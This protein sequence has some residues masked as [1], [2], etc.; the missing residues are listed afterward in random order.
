MFPQ[1]A[2]VTGYGYHRRMMEKAI[3]K[4]RC[5]DR[6]AEHL[7][8][9][10][11][12]KAEVRGQDHASLPVAG[13]DQL[14]EQ[15]GTTLDNRKEADLVDN[16]ERGIDMGPHLGL[17]Q[18]DPFG[19]DQV[20]DQIRKG[21]PVDTPAG[22]D[23]GNTDCGG[24]MGLAGSRG[25]QQMDH[26]APFDEGQFGQGHDPVA[27]EG[28]LEGEVEAFECLHRQQP[29]SLQGNGHAFRFALRAFLRQQPVD[30]FEGRDPA[31]FQGPD[32]QGKCFRGM[33]HP[34]ADR[35]VGKSFGNRGHRAPPICDRA[36]P[37]AAWMAR[38]RTGMPM[39]S[40]FRPVVTCD[41]RFSRPGGGERRCGGSVRDPCLPS[42]RGWV[43]IKLS[44]SS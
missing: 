41:N 32:D 1:P 7:P 18:S 29:G 5:H 13:I 2:A 21:D 23:G 17:Q 16:Q 25:T 3:Q 44:A 36:S 20:V 14:E 42:R 35:A 40:P 10:P 31:L 34:E 26:L 27:V 28:R 11:V 9:P 33:G 24:Q 4:C 15:A 43:A 8:P 12:G 19:L 39:E 22:P 37:M 30:G 38:G 6:V